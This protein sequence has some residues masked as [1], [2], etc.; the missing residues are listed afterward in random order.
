MQYGQF[1]VCGIPTGFKLFFTEL[2][3]GLAAYPDCSQVS[4]SSNSISGLEGQVVCGSMEKTSNINGAAVVALVSILFPIP[5]EFPTQAATVYSGVV[6]MH[7][8][9]RFPLE[10]PVFQAIFFLLEY[11]SQFSRSIGRT[12]SESTLQTVQAVPS[13]IGMFVFLPQA[14]FI[15]SA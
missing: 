7:Q 1:S 11:M 9:S 12:P 6:P 15:K 4:I 13:F 8:A 10:V 3:Y 14:L 2:Q 5:E